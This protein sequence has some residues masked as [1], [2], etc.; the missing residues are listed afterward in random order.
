MDLGY[1]SDGPNSFPF[2]T[3][4]K[5]AGARK[6]AL[7]CCARLAARLAANY[8]AQLAKHQRILI[9]CIATLQTHC[10]SLA[11]KNKAGGVVGK[12]RQLK[13]RFARHFG[14]ARGLAGRNEKCPSC[15]L[16][17]HK[18]RRTGYYCDKSLGTLF[19]RSTLSYNYT[20][21]SR[22]RASPALPLPL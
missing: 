19:G 1:R 7:C 14:Q 21:W 16:D 22:L 5:G 18:T 3:R 13:I 9:Y 2:C 15:L 17:L 20:P 12:C 6:R 8:F 4:P 11:L 10:K